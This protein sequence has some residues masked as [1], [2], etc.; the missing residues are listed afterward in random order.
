MHGEVG[1]SLCLPGRFCGPKDGVTSEG[2]RGISLPPRVHP[3]VAREA[4]GIG[5]RCAS[6]GLWCS[7]AASL[8]TL[9]FSARSHLGTKS[10][11]SSLQGAG[12]LWTVV[13]AQPET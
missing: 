12:L 2:V 7:Q 6:Q 4:V 8:R 10:M 3:S 13:R 11:I 5:T 1:A 9:L